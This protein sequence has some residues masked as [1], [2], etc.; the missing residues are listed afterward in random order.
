MSLNLSASV[1]VPTRGGIK[2]LPR[3]VEALS[4]QSL[5]DFE[6]IFVVDGDTDGSAVYLTSRE[7]ADRLPRSKVIN[8][9]QNRGRSEALN[10][11]HEASI[12]EVLIRCDDDLEPSVDYVQTHVNGQARGP[13]GVI[14]LYKNVFPD[15][16]YSRVYGADADRRFTESALATPANMQWR[17]WAG[18]VSISREIWRSV[19]TYDVRYRKYGWEDVDYGYRVFKAG[20]PVEIVPELTTAHHVAAVTTKIRGLRALHSGAAREKFVELHGTHALPHSQGT[21]MWDRAVAG[22]SAVSNEKS[23]EIIGGAVDSAISSLPEPVGR[24]LVALVVESAGLA[25]VR[26]PSRAKSSF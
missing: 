21:G 20:F 8:F 18:N 4:N 3:L 16:P 5:E 7:V 15:T 12:G 23:I 14:G 9:S 13:R 2:R 25:G 1:I 6:T 19:G 22:L 11:G 24:K 26:H 10:A 17:Y